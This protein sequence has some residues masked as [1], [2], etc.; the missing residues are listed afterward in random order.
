MNTLQQQF[1]G[2][3]VRWGLTLGSGW[4]M[5]RGTLK[6]GIDT[7]VIAAVAMAVPPLLWGLWQ[8]VKSRTAFKVALDLPAGATEADVKEA[9]KSTPAEK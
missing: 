6:D 1:L 2:S 4:L 7:E 9:I 8:K 3:L 5:A